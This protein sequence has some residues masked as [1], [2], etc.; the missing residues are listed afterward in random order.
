VDDSV[1]KSEK[2]VAER[3]NG[4]LTSARSITSADEMGR[5][6]L[7]KSGRQGRRATIKDVAAKAGVSFMTVSRAINGREGIRP[8]TRAAVMEAI[9]ALGY[10]PNVAARSLV[11]SGELRIGVIY[12]NPSAAFM[13][14]FLTG[15]FEEAASLGARLVILRAP[16]GENPSSKSLKDFIASGLSGVLLTPPLGDSIALLRMFARA[17]LPTAT[18][19]AYAADNAIS[20]R[21]NDRQAAYEMARHLLDLGHRRIGFIV[22]NPDQ[23]ASAE[24]LAGFYAAVREFEDVEASIAQGD[25]SFASGLVAAEQLLD[26]KPPPTAIFASNDDMAAAVVS[27]AHRRHLDVPQQLTVVGFD[28]TMTAVTMWPPLTTVHQPVRD[29]AAEALRLLSAQVSAPTGQTAASGDYLL[30]HRIVH[31]Q[32]EAPPADAGSMSKALPG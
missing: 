4:L 11:T 30:D 31:R 3:E 17:H 14:E 27:V 10:K 15:A 21:I 29:L 1:A 24:R 19:A 5:A 13:S 23:A 9:D 2:R 26:R 7:N 32:S 22:G 25:F 12:S 16:K 18:V 6:T 8:E 20:V 28:D